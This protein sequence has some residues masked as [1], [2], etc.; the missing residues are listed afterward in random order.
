MPCLTVT[1]S[2]ELNAWIF[3]NLSLYFLFDCHHVLQQHPRYHSSFSGWLSCRRL[4]AFNAS[5]T[6]A[7]LITPYICTY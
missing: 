5:R 2:V 1:V 4:R 6:I 7:R 3:Y